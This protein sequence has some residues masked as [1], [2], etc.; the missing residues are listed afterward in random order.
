MFNGVI[1]G[2]NGVIGGYNVVIGCYKMIEG[3]WGYLRLNKNGV[4]YR[5][6]GGSNV[7]I[8]GYWCYWNENRRLIVLK[9]RNRR[10]N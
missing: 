9:S 4:F 1:G 2:Y 6:L 7:G 10:F 5:L 3:Y 8:R